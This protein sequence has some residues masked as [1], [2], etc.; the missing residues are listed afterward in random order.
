MPSSYRSKLEDADPEKAQAA[1][2]RVL[3]HCAELGLL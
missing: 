1:A 3:D 2:I